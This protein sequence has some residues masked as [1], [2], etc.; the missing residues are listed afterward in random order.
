VV[1]RVGASRLQQLFAA[2]WDP[3]YDVVEQLA[4]LE[5]RLHSWAAEHPGSVHHDAAP[6]GPL[7]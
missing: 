5:G 1:E 2:R 3:R 7:V 4:R 6:S